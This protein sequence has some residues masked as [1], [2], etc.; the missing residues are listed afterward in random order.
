MGD[1]V[2]HYQVIARSYLL[3]SWTGCLLT[4]TLFTYRLFPPQG[5]QSDLRPR[6]AAIAQVHGPLLPPLRSVALGRLLNFSEET[7][8]FFRF[9]G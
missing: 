5:L 8:V 3:N 7:I 9:R 2:S 1:S 4:P 6:Q